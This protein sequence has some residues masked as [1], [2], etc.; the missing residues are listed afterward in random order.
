MTIQQLR[1]AIA[2]AETGSITEAAR[3]L[4]VAQPSISSAIRDLETEIGIRIFVR[5]RA[6]ISITAEGMEF[7]G[8]ARQVAEPMQALTDRYIS[9]R[10]ERQRFCVSTQHYTFTSNAFVRMV[11]QYGLERYEF[12]L[13]ETQTNQILQDVRNRFCDVGVLYQSCENHAV[14][15]KAFADMDLVF[16]PLFTAMPHVFLHRRHPLAVQHTVTLHDLEPYPRLSFLQGAYESPFF[17]EELF[18]TVSA[19]KNI[20]VSDRAAIVNLMI[21]LHGYTISSGIFPRHLQGDEIIAL[22]LAAEEY[23]EIGYLLNRD[24]TLSDLGKKYI[25][26]LREYSETPDP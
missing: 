7:L 10:P 2:V 18:S 1:Y 6:G 11:Q 14:L 25:E 15:Q 9:G 19:E 16:T 8:Y 4:F 23:M 17:S 22:P 5:S 13:N 3:R 20:K 26:A 12:I 21:G 24:Q